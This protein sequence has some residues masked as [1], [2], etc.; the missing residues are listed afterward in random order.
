MAL[1]HNHPSGNTTPSISD[2][3]L[4]Y[5]IKESCKIMNITLVDHLVVCDG[6]YYSFADNGLI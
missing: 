1:I 6:D 2:K 4:T 3:Q 5:K